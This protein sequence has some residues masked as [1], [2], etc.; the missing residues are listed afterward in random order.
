MSD[1]IGNLDITSKYDLVKFD[2]GTAFQCCNY[3]LH[4]CYL[5]RLQVRIVTVFQGVIVE[6]ETE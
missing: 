1:H 2:G 4:A 5:H 3:L 6:D